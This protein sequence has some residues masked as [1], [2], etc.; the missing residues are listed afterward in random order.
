MPVH[1]TA[2]RI[3]SSKEIFILTRGIVTNT[4]SEIIM[5]L[6]FTPV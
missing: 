5:Y 1:A 2:T 6:F 4:K 3:K